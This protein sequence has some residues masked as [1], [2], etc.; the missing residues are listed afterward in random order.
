MTLHESEQFLKH[1]QFSDSVYIYVCQ[2]LMYK[3]SFSIS[4][5]FWYVSEWI[6][7]YWA[8]PGHCCC[9]FNSSFSNLELFVSEKLIYSNLSFSFY[10]STVLAAVLLEF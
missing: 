3:N 6:N 7:K 9:S 5:T 2:A 4:N 1:A 8:R 10:T